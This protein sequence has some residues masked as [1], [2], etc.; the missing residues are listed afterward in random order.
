MARQ[1]PSEDP[2]EG[3]LA[4]PKLTL[5]GRLQGTLEGR[6]FE[7]QAEGQGLALSLDSLGSVPHVLRAVRLLL[8]GAAKLDYRL[9]PPVKVRVRGLPS[10]TVRLGSPIWRLFLGVG[11]K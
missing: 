5:A 7:V 4:E 2:H 10:V 3:R 9:L 6:P 8:P 11:Q 1:R